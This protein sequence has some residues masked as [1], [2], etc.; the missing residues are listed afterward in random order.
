MDCTQ[1]KETCQQQGVRGYPT[2]VLF[3]DG[4]VVQKYSGSRTFED[5]VTFVT[6]NMAEEEEEEEL[7]GPLDLT[8]ETFAS[9]IAE[10]VTFVKFFA[11]WCG[12][13]KQLAPTWEELA[14]KV[15]ASSNVKIA[16]V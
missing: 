14:S 2:L 12:H 15:H 10:G 13:C 16:K 8:G 3:E 4:L 1:E 11:P 7:V 6:D 5:L 9:T